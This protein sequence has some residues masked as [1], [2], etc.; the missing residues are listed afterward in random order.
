MAAALLLAACAVGP[1]FKPPAPP[2][3]SGYT[4]NPVATTAATPGVAGGE[5]QHLESG[6]DIP[7]DWWTLFHSAPLDALIQQ[8]LT[9]NHDLKAAQAALRVAHEN[10]LAQRGAFL[11]SVSANLSASRQRQPGSLAPVPESN[12]FLYNLYTPQLTVSYTPDVFGANRRS[13]ESLKA[14]EQAAR[15]Q[16]I[17][18]WNTLASNVAVAAIQL[19]SLQAQVDATRQLVDAN[20]RMLDILRY[21]FAK[22]YASRIDLAAQESQLAQ[23]EATLPPLEKQLAQQRDQLAVLAGRFPSQATGDQITLDSLQ[24]PETLPLSLPS[25]LVAQRPDV[26]QA[27]ANLHAAS[28]EVGVATAARLP[29]ITLTAD[30]G[31]TAL[32]FSK[33]FTGGTGFWDVAAGITAPIFEGGTLL[34]QQ[35]AAKAAYVE[36][37]EQYRSTVLT[38]FQNVADTLVALDQDAKAL[39]ATAKTEQAAKLTLALVQ[40]QLKDGYAGGLQLLNAEQSY[41]QARIALVQAQANRF[42][43]SA[44]LYQAL[45]GGWWHHSD[46]S[47]Q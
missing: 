39:Q 41:Q 19:A 5:A 31:S 17:A 34:H 37:S 21:Q 13:V 25:A 4:P 11:P 15:F 46:L 3:V 44:A 43:D 14:Q 40:R 32:E 9:R 6:A 36:A 23:T 18:T 26:R 27:Q 7:G 45:G 22:G 8:A 29:N 20:T 10:M 35:R 38:A 12:A 2:A 47:K 30:T 42:A 24:L 28:A 16:M 1:D 33:L